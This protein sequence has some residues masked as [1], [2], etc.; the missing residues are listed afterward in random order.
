MSTPVRAGR[1]SPAKVN[2]VASSD[3]EEDVVRAPV[4]GP[5]KKRKAVIADSESDFENIVEA[6]SGSE[7]SG[8]KDSGA[9]SDFESVEG[10]RSSSALSEVAGSEN[11]E[12]DEEV[13]VAKVRPRQLCTRLWLTISITG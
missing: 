3:E 4:A 6:E 5:S 11:E 1:R 9:E 13:V 7:G 2:Y 8:S 12:S 10:K